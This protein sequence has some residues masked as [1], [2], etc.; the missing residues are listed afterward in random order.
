MLEVAST[1]GPAVPR[2]A[3]GKRHEGHEAFACR[4]G[5]RVTP[6]LLASRAS[7]SAA[8]DSEVVSVE[9]SRS[10]STLPDHPMQCMACTF[11]YLQL[12]RCCRSPVL[13]QVQGAVV[14]TIRV[15]LSLEIVGVGS[16]PAML[17]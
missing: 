8:T 14:G 17:P 1:L 5:G 15:N 2:S 12:V 3:L 16:S 13:S 6:A 10:G 4:G 7:G 11:G 9:S